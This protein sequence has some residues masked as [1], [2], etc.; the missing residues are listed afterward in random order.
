MERK[1]KTTIEMVTLRAGGRSR[2]EGS[3]ANARGPDDDESVDWTGAGQPICVKRVI[4]RERLGC[5]IGQNG[6]R[7]RAVDVYPDVQWEIHTTIHRYTGM[8]L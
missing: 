6:G 4:C 8:L 5:R 7:R 3:I 1:T 2:T